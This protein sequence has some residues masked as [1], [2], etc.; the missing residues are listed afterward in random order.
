MNILYFD[1][2]IS[3]TKYLKK[4][5]LKTFLYSLISNESTKKVTLINFIFCS[6]S[7]LLQINKDFLKHNYFTD[8]ITFDYS[9]Q[10]IESDIFISFDRIIEN[11]EK[12]S[13]TLQSELHRVIFH[14]ILHL[15][16]YK[17]KTP[18]QK[19]VMTEKENYYLDLYKNVTKL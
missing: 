6:D 15:V 13:V 10:S 11:A 18:Q 9:E 5:L 7:Y 3:A 16:G 19:Q 17:D 4:R 14:G 12:N 2:D 8:I 1:Q